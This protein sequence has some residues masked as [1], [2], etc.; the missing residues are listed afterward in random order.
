MLGERE[1]LIPGSEL[2]AVND[3]D[4]DLYT[5]VHAIFSFYES[6]SLTCS[7]SE[8]S[9]ETTHPF[10][11]LVGFLGIKIG[12]SKCLYLHRTNNTQMRKHI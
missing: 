10:R 9:S 12:L 5:A 6:D 3:S 4:V 8:L 7:N 1:P 11:H 2:V